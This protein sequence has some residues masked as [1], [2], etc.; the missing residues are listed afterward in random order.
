MALTHEESARLDKAMKLCDWLEGG[1]FNPDDV[2]EFADEHWSLAAKGAGITFPSEKTQ[3][4][5][6]RLFRRRA[7]MV[8]ADPFEGLPQ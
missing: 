4:M 7:V 1:G 8:A 5:V 2:A 3:E 6:V